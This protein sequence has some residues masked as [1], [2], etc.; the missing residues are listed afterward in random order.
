MS[1]TENGF[2]TTDWN[3]IVVEAAKVM[4]ERLRVGDRDLPPW[5]QLDDDATDHYCIAAQNCVET[6]HWEASKMVTVY[7]DFH[8]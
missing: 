3:P 7:R 8:G 5:S 1:S 4:Y 6:F 2:R